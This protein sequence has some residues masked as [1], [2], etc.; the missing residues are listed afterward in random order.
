MFIGASPGSTGGG[1]K[2]TT[3]LLTILA[4]WSLL[5]GRDRVEY[6]GRTIPSI[7][8][9]RALTIVALSLGLVMIF[10]LFITLFE[11]Q[12]MLFLDHMF[13]VTSAFGTVGLST[14][15]TPQLSTPS[16]FV[17][18]LTMFIGRVGPLT[19]LIAMAGRAA[20]P[21]YEFPEEKIALG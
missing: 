10:T 4:L 21:R 18:I 2:T 15:I 11:N 1:V 12:P 16:Q 13:E 19:L 20:S 3:F 7:Q 6:R 5:Q 17:I 9:N 8:V 14:G